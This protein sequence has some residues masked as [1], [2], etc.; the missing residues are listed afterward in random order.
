MVMSQPLCLPGSDGAA[1]EDDPGD[2]EA[3]ERHGRG[4]DGFVAGDEGGHAI[5][6]VAADEEFDGVGDNLAADERSLHA[7]RAHRDAVGNG[8][9]VELHGGA[10]SGANALFHLH[11]EL[12][13]VVVA[14]HG[15][16]P[17]VGD[18]DDGLGEIFVGEPDGLQHG[19]SGGAVASLGDG[20]ALQFHG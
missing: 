6:H 14:W 11:G 17:G 2:V 13:E 12:A 8:D 3:Q 19:A 4:G 16:N 9:G 7:L 5:E 15:F 20:V 10:A 18:T 1:V